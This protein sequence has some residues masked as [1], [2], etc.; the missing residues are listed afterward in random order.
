VELSGARVLLTGASS[1]IGAAVAVALG[2]AGATVGLVARRAELLDDVLAAAR[3]AGATPDSRCWVVDLADL[4]AAEQVAHQA[5]EA[6]G[7]LEAFVSNAALHRRRSALRLQARELDELLRVNFLAPAHMTLAL[8]PRMLEQGRGTILA[9]GSVAGRVCSPGESAY[10]ASKH[11]LTGFTENLAVDLAGTPVL[12]RLVTPGPFD[13]PIWSVHDD[14][15][16]FYAGPKHP[17]SMAADVIV[18]VLRGTDRFETFTPE[19]V[20]DTVHRKQA[21]VDAWIALAAEMG[22]GTA[23]ARVTYPDS[24]SQWDGGTPLRRQSSAPT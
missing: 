5:W 3:D 4:E 11:A 15:P 19:A 24:A 8:V 2:R 7:G 12:V 9:V 21:D 16:S 18:D 6:F 17:P 20:A 13:T 14:E 23:P 10:V 1:G 22:A